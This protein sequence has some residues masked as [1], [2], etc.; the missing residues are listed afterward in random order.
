MNRRRRLRNIELLVR[1]LDGMPFR[2]IADQ[3]GLSV[4]SVYERCFKKAQ[5]L[6][7]CADITRKYCGRFSGLLVTDGKYI[8][9]K[10]YSRKIPVIYGIDYLTH[11]VPTYRLAPSESFQSLNLFFKSLRLLNYP[12]KGTVSDDNV[13]IRTAC[14]SVYP[15]T[16]IQLCYVHY[17]RS[18]RQVLNPNDQLHKNFFLDLRFLFKEKRSEDDFNRI[19]KEMYYKYNNNQLLLGIL[20]DLNYRKEYLLAYLKL[21]KLPRSTN[22]IEAYNSHLQA[23][24]SSIKGFQ[25]F[26]HANTWINAYFLYRRFRK[27]TDC[28]KRFKSLNGKSSLEMSRLQDINLPSFF[29]L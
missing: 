23:W 15:K 22:L 2:K 5:E 1:F 4:G 29:D 9:V 6:P 8:A 12:L 20:L 18:I 28:T 25:S 27:F 13:N 26:N 19:S 3:Y 24:L 14:L 10:G 21:K 7:H 17:L 16:V 11:D